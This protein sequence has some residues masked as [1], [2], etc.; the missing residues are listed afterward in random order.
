MHPA[1]PN[2]LGLT[3]THHGVVAALDHPSPASQEDTGYW[4]SLQLG[5]PVVPR[6]ISLG[7]H[8]AQALRIPYTAPGYRKERPLHGEDTSISGHQPPLL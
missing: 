4:K 7:T 6:D 5:T 8:R 3:K 2:K 1:L